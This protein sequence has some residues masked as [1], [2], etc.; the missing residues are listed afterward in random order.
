M[1][2]V[3]SCCS[4]TGECSSI[5][6]MQAVR[7]AH[8]RT[9]APEWDAGRIEQRQRFAAEYG[10][11]VASDYESAAR[12]GRRQDVSLYR[13]FELDRRVCVCVPQ[14]YVKSSVQRN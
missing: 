9:G 3:R 8:W 2:L 1:L 10:Y 5:F 6:R 14:N 12:M 4:Q 13:A 7:H 11:S